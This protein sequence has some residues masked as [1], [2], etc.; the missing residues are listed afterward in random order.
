MRQQLPTKV[1]HWNEEQTARASVT[2]P[3]HPW[4]VT[5]NPQSAEPLGY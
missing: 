3:L 5:I 4:P 2:I 1:S